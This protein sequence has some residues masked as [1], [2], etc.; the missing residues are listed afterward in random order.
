[1]YM[2][3]I[4]LKAQNF[5]RDISE[6]FQ[7]KIEIPDFLNNKEQKL[8]KEPKYYD[9]YVNAYEDVRFDLI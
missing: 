6:I 9:K 7:K 5:L 4:S 1:M 8:R 3:T 2:Y